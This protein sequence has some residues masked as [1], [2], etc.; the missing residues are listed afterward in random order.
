MENTASG[1]K[2]Y[3]SAGGGVGVVA[4]YRTEFGNIVRGEG[5]DGLIRNLHAKNQ[6]LEQTG[7]QGK[8]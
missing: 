6:S 2:V 5:I 3:D 7:E 8:K 1:G 4:N